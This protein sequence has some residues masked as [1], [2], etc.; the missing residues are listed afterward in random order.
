MRRTRQ[1][2]WIRG[3]VAETSLTVKDLIQGVFVVEGENIRHP[4]PSMPGIF[5]LSIDRLI[6]EI[7]LLVDLGLPAILLFPALEADVKSETAEEAYNPD[8]LIARAIRRIKR[9]T[10]NIGVF[11]DVA[12]DP[13][14]SHGHDGLMENGEILNDPTLE[15]LCRQALV[16]A[17]AGVDIVA[18]SDMMDGRVGAL[19]TALDGAGFQSVGICA[20]AAKYASAL[21]GPF[22]QAVRSQGVLRGDK[23]TYQMDPSNSD[24]ALREVALDLQEGADLIMI[25][26]GLPYLDIVHRVKTRFQVPVCLYHV[27]GEYAML[28]AAC[29]RGW[30]VYEKVLM[31]S[32]LCA[33]RAGADMIVTYGAKD[34]ARLLS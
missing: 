15:A 4:I 10:P 26:P 18:P 7:H 22:R 28:R 16:L 6:D 25:K 30:L 32:A 21:Y 2:P 19:R 8:S 17:Q 31:E 11:V 34:L 29:D 3:L 24:E 20:Y 33:K 27:S 13:Y 9:E 12:L 5:H 1:F 23:A 14:T